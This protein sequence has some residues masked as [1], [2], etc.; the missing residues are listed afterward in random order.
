MTYIGNAVTQLDGSKFAHQNCVLATTSVLIDS[1]SLGYWKVKPSRLRTLSGDTSGGVTYSLA[2]STAAK[3]TDKEVNLTTVYWAPENSS[4][5][6]LDNILSAPRLTAISIDAGVTR[7]T[8]FR[9]GTF[10]GG[11]T[12]TVGGKRT[13]LV[14]RED[15]SRVNQK[16]AYV[17]DSGHSDAKWVWWP[18]SLLIKAAKSRTGGNSIHV[19]Y[20]RDLGGTKRVA[21]GKGAIRSSAKVTSTNRVGSLVAGQWYTVVST[22]K[23]GTYTLDGRTMNG[24][25]KLG[26]GKYC[27]AKIR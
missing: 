15:G 21:K 6:T 9:T 10:T 5:S 13:I 20:T 8:P 11:H 14:T 27:V 19:L 7:Y 17:M 3:A 16:Q 25:N 22:V 26:T 1:A 23:G 2:E 12:V 18:W 24:W 4:E